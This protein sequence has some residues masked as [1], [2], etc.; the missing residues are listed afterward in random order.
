MTKRIFV[1][2]LALCMII[3]LLPA[4]APVQNEGDNQNPPVNAGEGAK[5]GFAV[6][7]NAE[8]SKAATAGEPGL[9]QTD[10]TQ[11]AV[12]TDN[13]GRIIKC[14]IDS[15]QSKINF[16]GTG[17]ITTDLTARVKSKLEL[18][19]EY[20][21][22][23]AS[24]IGKEWNEQAAALADYVQG[25]TLDEVRGIAV[26]DQGAPT[27][28]DLKSSVTVSIGGFIEAIEKAVNN[29][30]ATGAGAD[31]KLGLGIVTSIAKSKNAAAGEDGL[32][33]TYS[34]YAVVTFDK[35]N[36]IT[37]CL[38]DASQININ[39][40]ATGGL[41]TDL[42]AVFKTKQ[43]LGEEYGMKKASGIGKEWS[44]QA[45]A[46][47]EYVIGKTVDEVKGIA[48]NEE[49]RATGAELTGSVTI[50]IADAIETI[51]KAFN[52]AK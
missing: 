21:L 9:A 27:G 26:N 19:E 11:V 35:D 10:S 38:I 8:K 20:G 29:A 18:G 24:G 28:E 1:L 25:K 41:V 46:F 3:A 42:N 6:I 32:A 51:E 33:Q 39:F 44:E 43:E 48:V 2:L 23:K 13:D 4:C 34:N 12:L 15:V 17:E 22:K 16:S 31:D 50:S 5:V 47:A 36:K 40:N 7:T 14:I 37:S 30:K 49:G 52:S 45:N